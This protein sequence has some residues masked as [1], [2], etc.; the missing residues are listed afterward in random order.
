MQISKLII[1]IVFP[2]SLWGQDSLEYEWESVRDYALNEEEVWSVDGLENVFTTD[3]TVINKYDSVGVLKFSQ[4]IKSLGETSQFVP[5]NTMKLVHFSIEQQTLCYFDNTLTI[6][7]DCLE[8]SDRDVVYASLIA[9][10]ER[11]D[12]L[13]VLDNVNYS[14]RLLDLEGEKFQA[15]EINNLR[16]VL[17]LDNICQIKERFNQLYVVDSLKGVFIFDM[18]GS[19]VDRIEIEGATNVDANEST[20]FILKDNTFITHSLTSNFETEIELPIDDVSEFVLE[21]RSFFFRSK[22]IVHKYHLQISN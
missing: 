7:E 8:L 14:L 10:S 20:V 21:N 18:Y 19:L 22:K 9:T 17:G 11:S 12:K 5:I 15:I 1:L 16:G 13:W 2:L 4:S 6:S 3:R